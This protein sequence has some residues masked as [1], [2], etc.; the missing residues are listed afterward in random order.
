MWC[1]VTVNIL[2][3]TGDI[4]HRDY[5]FSEA[6]KKENKKLCACVSRA[7]N[8]SLTIETAYKAL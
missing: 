2:D 4:D 5:F 1:F 7:V 6:Q 3:Y 8:G